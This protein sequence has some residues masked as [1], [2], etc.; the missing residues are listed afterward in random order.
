[1]KGSA[2][3]TIDA[4]STPN[5]A[6]AGCSAAPAT[7]AA[8]IARTIDQN[9]APMSQRGGGRRAG[10]PESVWDCASGSGAVLG[11]L[12][13]DPHYAAPARGPSVAY[14]LLCHPPVTLHAQ[15]AAERVEERLHHIPI[16]LAAGACAELVVGLLVGEG[17]PVGA[18]IGHRLV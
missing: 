11:E 5:V 15:P 13:I 10:A 2:S 9:A 4:N 12:A 16:E 17:G 7:R 3:T 1:M 14:G 6:M 18:L 8:T